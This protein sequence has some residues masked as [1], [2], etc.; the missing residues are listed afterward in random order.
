MIQQGYVVLD[1]HLRTWFFHMPI[2][3]LR[4]TSNQTT[5]LLFSKLIKLRFHNDY[6]IFQNEK[7][8]GYAMKF[9]YF[10]YR[11]FCDSSDRFCR[12]GLVIRRENREC[13][14]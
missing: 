7:R 13:E 10:V 11:T 14:R 8:R 9:T 6:W 1:C 5:G 2:S 12:I 3:T 4:D